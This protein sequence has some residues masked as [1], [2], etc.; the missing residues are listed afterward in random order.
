LRAELRALAARCRAELAGGPEG[1]FTSLCKDVDHLAARLVGTEL[2][3]KIAPLS[4]N[5]HLCAEIASETELKEDAARRLREA[6]LYERASRAE[7]AALEERMRLIRHRELVVRT[8]DAIINTTGPLLH[9][10]AKR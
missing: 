10:P 2:E 4:T 7:D 3:L 9:R 5:L 1:N 8:A 6:G